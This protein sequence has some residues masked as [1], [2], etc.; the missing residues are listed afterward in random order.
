[1]SLERIQKAELTNACEI[2]VAFVKL[3][4]KKISFLYKGDTSI[5]PEQLSSK[6]AQDPCYFHLITLLH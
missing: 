2:L 4:E 5:S 1:V 6:I 3:K